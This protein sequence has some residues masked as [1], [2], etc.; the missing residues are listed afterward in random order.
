M[1]LQPNQLISDQVTPQEITLIMQLLDNVLADTVTGDVVEFGC[2]VGT[3]SVFLQDAIQDSDKRLHVYDSFEGLPQKISKDESPSGTDFR[4]GE[5]KASKKELV[6][7]FRKLNLPLPTIHKNWFS[8]LSQDD[9]PDSICFAFLD[10]DYHDSILDPLKLIWNHLE[11][12]AI[13]VVDDYANDA[14][15][16]ARKAVDEWLV[17]HPAKLRVQS[18]LAILY[19]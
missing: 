17:T 18:S 12:G 4:A 1:R 8:E 15:P 11:P 16:G 14:L 2:Y 9:I 5:L 7:H 3:T 13:V 19:T 6:R 10:G